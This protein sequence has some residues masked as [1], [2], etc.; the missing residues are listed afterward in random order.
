MERFTCSFI[1]SIRPFVTNFKEVAFRTEELHQDKIIIFCPLDREHS[2]APFQ[3]TCAHNH[4]DIFL[5]GKSLPNFVFLFW[6]I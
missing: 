1:V 4:V 6:V 2:R 3:M 5:L